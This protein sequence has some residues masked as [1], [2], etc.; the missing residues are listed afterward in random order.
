[1]MTKP[2]LSTGLRWLWL[3]VLVIG[4]DFA[5]KQWI[6]D[7]LMLHESMPVMPYFNF[8]YA[9]NYGAAFSFLA[10]KGAGSAGSLPALPL[11]SSWCCW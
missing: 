2:V 9:H 10:D 3:V 6:M 11:L 5:S 1:M 7:N 4:I 8:F